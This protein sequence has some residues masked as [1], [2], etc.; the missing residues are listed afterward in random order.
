[1]LVGPMKRLVKDLFIDESKL[2]HSVK[3]LVDEAVAEVHSLAAERG[4]VPVEEVETVAEDILRQPK[5]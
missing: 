5:R 3:K 2:H 1:M 4:E